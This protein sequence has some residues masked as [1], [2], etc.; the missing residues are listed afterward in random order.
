VLVGN[1]SVSVRVNNAIEMIAEGLGNKLLLSFINRQV[2]DKLF[3]D[4][5]VPEDD[6]LYI[7]FHQG[8]NRYTCF[9][10][11]PDMSGDLARVKFKV[12]VIEAIK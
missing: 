7:I 10:Y 1:S 4:F 8:I 11:F 6:T 9:V 3:Y 5:K 2:I 12:L